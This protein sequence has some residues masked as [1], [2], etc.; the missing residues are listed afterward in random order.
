MTIAER[1]DAAAAA[2]RERA[3]AAPELGLILG[4]GLGDFADRLEDRT[5]VPFADLP[6]FP[7]STVAGHRGA[8]VFG[9]WAGRWWPSAAAS[10]T[11]R[12]T[13]SR[14]S[15]CPCGSWPGWG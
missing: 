2:I 14:R 7:R 8:F 13:P 11:T 5:V 15:P 9:T 10:T 12:A 6:G 1:I 4:S 3:A